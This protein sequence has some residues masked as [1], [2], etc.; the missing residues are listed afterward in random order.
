MRDHPR[1]DDFVRHAENDEPFAALLQ[2]LLHDTGHR[3]NLPSS[4]FDR[5]VREQEPDQRYRLT[6][7][8][9]KIWR[10]HFPMYRSDEY[11]TEEKFRAKFELCFQQYRALH[12]SI[13][14]YVFDPLT[15]AFLEETGPPPHNPRQYL[16]RKMAVD[17]MYTN[18][19]CIRFLREHN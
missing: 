9:S 7:L 14:T 13:R 17:K 4:I 10:E 6:Q 15:I 8:A 2:L 12:L 19:Y 5:I 16:T 1:I 18:D 3:G 11:D